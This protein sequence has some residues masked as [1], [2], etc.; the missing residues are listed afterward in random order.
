VHGYRL[1]AVHT[2]GSHVDLTDAYADVV[3]EMKAVATAL[4]GGALREISAESFHA[5]LPDIRPAVGDRALL[6]A[7]HFFDENERVVRQTALLRAGDIEGFLA[8]VR[9]SADS[10]WRLLQNCYP[11]GTSEHQDVA[12]AIALSETF[13]AGDGGGGLGSRAARRDGGGG[14]G[15]GAARGDGGGGRAVEKHTGGAA[16]VHGG[17]FA[18]TIQT[19]VPEERA[20]AYQAAMA[21]VFGE[22]SVTEL[23]IRN[24][25][26][27]ELCRR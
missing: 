12:L 11:P 23:R 1:Y 9:G 24:V 25:G 10:S 21:A 7:L 4:G 15:S 16:R 6:R 19:Y 18:G 22:D 13:L 17:G 5:R 14:Q 26:A 8:E 20:D 2:G 27:V 3:T